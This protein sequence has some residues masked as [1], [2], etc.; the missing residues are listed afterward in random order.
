MKAQHVVAGMTLSAM[1]AVSTPAVS[2]AQTTEGTLQAGSTGSTV[3]LLQ[4]D[5]NALGYTVG[6]A[7]GQF[8]VK[9]TTEVEAFQ[10]AHKLAADGVVGAAT[11][12]VLDAAAAALVTKPI[13]L[14]ASSKAAKS[15]GVKHIYYNNELIT[16]PYGFTYDNTTYMPIW[17]VMETLDKEGFTHTWSGNVW[18]II[19]PNTASQSI[20]YSD[21]RYGKGSMAIAINGTVVARVIGVTHVDPASKSTTTFMPIYYVEQALNR[22]GITSDWNGTTW[23]MKSNASQGGG[24]ST[25]VPYGNVDLRFPAPGSITASSID[26]YLSKSAYQGTIGSPLTGL[27]ASFIDAQNTYGVDATYLV[28]HALLESAYGTSAIAQQDNNLFGYG[29]YTDNPGQ[30]AGVFP[31]DDYAIRFQ[32]WE[33]RNNYL[34]PAGSN[35]GAPPHSPG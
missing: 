33:V 18:N 10:K 26:S 22:I 12:K 35:Y 27:G 28:A 29:A 17:Y 34:N 30:D 8:G 6:Q 24:G 9:T 2:Y 5:L 4:N 13:A 3:V 15:I 21:I 7:D 31:S 20:D 23:K 14:S 19:V 16:S 1:V 11:W 25:T 32:A